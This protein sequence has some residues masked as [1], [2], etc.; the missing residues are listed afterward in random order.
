MVDAHTDRC[1]SLEDAV[2]GVKTN[3]PVRLRMPADEE[4][5]TTDAWDNHEA[6]DKDHEVVLHWNHIHMKAEEGHREVHVAGHCREPECDTV[7]VLVA[8]TEEADVLEPHDL[9]RCFS[10][11]LLSS[12]LSQLV[13]EGH[14][15]A[16]L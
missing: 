7:L 3:H 10:L 8:D 4:A 16:H 1:H 15:H 5:E 2:Q 12:S 14:C 13:E 11:K 9:F 6:H